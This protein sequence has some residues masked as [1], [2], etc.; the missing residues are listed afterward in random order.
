MRDLRF[1]S[2]VGNRFI[3]AAG[4]PG[5]G[6]NWNESSTFEFQVYCMQ[7]VLQP[8]DRVQLIIQFVIKSLSLHP[9]GTARC[10]GLLQTSHAKIRIIRTCESRARLARVVV[11][12]TGSCEA[13]KDKVVGRNGGSQRIQQL[14]AFCWINDSILSNPL[15]GIKGAI[16]LDKVPAL[17]GA[18]FRDASIKIRLGWTTDQATTNDVEEEVELASTSLIDEV[19]VVTHVLQDAQ[20]LADLPRPHTR[21]QGVAIDQAVVVEKALSHGEVVSTALSQSSR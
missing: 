17:V 16:Q 4:V 12:G 21:W 10:F 19:K 15:Y 7:L 14:L 2:W 9:L 6:K 8:K 18:R 1:T 11:Q 13:I 3:L 5:R 20:V